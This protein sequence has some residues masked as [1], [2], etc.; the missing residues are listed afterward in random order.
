LHELQCGHRL[1]ERHDLHAR[2]LHAQ[3]GGV[4]QRTERTQR[5][6]DDGTLL[7]GHLRDGE[8]EQHIR[9]APRGERDG[10]SAQRPLRRLCVER[11]HHGANAIDGGLSRLL[12]RHAL[13]LQQ[14]LQRLRGRAL[15]RHELNLRAVVGTHGHHGIGP[16]GGLPPSREVELKAQVGVQKA[17][18]GEVALSRIFSEHHA[19]HYAQVR[20]AMHRL[21][22]Q[23]ARRRLRNAL[24]RP[25]NAITRIRVRALPFGHATRATTQSPE[26][27]EYL[28]RLAH[29]EPLRQ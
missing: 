17:R 8:P 21:A 20:V 14:S 12:H 10:Q 19:V 26:H 24:L 18:A 11:R 23:R 15:S 6:F 5:C 9:T 7:R 16:I 25:L 3:R 27:R 1:I 2:R 4:G 22:C 29:V 28:G 13:L